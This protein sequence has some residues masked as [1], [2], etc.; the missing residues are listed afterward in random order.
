M[1]KEQDDILLCCA[2]DASNNKVLVGTSKG[3]L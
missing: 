1:S 3:S 2:F